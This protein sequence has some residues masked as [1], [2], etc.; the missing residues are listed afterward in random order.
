MWEFEVGGLGQV[1]C[2]ICSAEG[3]FVDFLLMEVTYFVYLASVK[4]LMAM[5]KVNSQSLHSWQGR[6]MA[7]ASMIVEMSFRG[8]IVE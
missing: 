6:F 1:C 7:R 8:C 4:P 3:I 5:G 2:T